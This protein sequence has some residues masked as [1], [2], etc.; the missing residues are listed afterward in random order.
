MSKNKRKKTLSRDSGGNLGVEET[1][2]DYFLQYASYV[3]TDRA[4]PDIEDGLKPVQRRILFSL[5]ENEDGRY[6]K[7]ANIVG[8]CMKYHPHGD[9]SIFSAMVGL[10]QKGLLIDTQGNWGD[11]VTNDRAA[12][13]RY[14]EARLTAF[15]K[16]VAFAPH[17]TTYKHSYDGRSKEPLTLPV[18]FPLLLAMGAEGIAVGL[19]T[20]ILPHNFIE[21]L[22]AQK[23]HLRGEDFTLL[24][25]FPTGGLID[26]K[27]YMDGAPGS[28]VKVRA[29][30]ERGK[31]KSV[32]IREVPYG[33]STESLI[34]S[35]L[36]ANEKGKIKVSNIQDNSAAK[37]EIVVSFQRG[38][39]MDKAEDALYA[40]TDCEVSLSSNSMVI[41]KGKP[42]ALSASEILIESTKRTRAL[43]RRDLEI[44]LERLERL[45]HLKSLVQI[46]VENRIYLRIEKCE[47][48]VEVLY[49]IDRGLE[50]HLDRLRRPVTEEDLVYL[51]E[52][53]IRRISAWDS[54]KAE[55]ELNKIDE[56]M[57]KVRRNLRNLTP[58]TID[59]L[60]N[61]LA[62]YGK[63]RE[64]RTEICS[65]DTVAAVSVVE[66]TE[67]L[68]IERKAGFIGTD[69][70]DGEELGPCSPLDD[71][72]VVLQ[73]G[74]MVVARVADRKYL[75]ENIMYASLIRPGA[76][77][78]VFNLIYEDVETGRVY[79]KRF[80]VG[81]YTRERR[82]ELGPAKKKKALLLAIGN[83]VCAHIKL[84]KKPR[85]RTDV[86]LRFDELLVKGRGAAG[87]TVTRHQASSAREISEAVYCSRL[88]LDPSELAKADS[89][90]DTIV[91]QGD[92]AENGIAEGSKPNGT[93]IDSDQPSDGHQKPLFSD[94]K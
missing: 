49:E 79:A 16:E 65:F 60:D 78:T 19:T 47:T 38:V 82:Y 93:P 24:P 8:H 2:K 7:V 71:V 34:D 35:I 18:R 80:T 42:T 68:Y 88:K 6:G 29:V 9:A 21:L 41:R 86:Y 44:E 12:A 57:S 54:K 66:R 56:E 15:A 85:I 62:K 13:A 76:R 89:P 63:G 37:I 43:L 90:G 74:G 87:N 17:L 3:I 94:E 55:E 22:E 50:P 23:A 36:K 81:G 77:D 25:D 84:R 31:G 32:I 53:K 14:I 67:K 26:V 91:E 10:G 83:G 1:F 11:S 20:R 30:I 48:W 28:R 69:L 58:F 73:D 59:Y 72:M 33:T 51:T 4:I 92:R 40:F 39:D 45:W 52:V 75:G 64:R 27:D 46:F 70:K 61:L 5:W